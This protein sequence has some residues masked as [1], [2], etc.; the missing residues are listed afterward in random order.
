M[1][2]GGCISLGDGGELPFAPIV[3]ALRGLPAILAENA[4]GTLGRI[5]E[6][7]SPAT[8]ELGRL[9]PELGSS[10][11]AEQG[12][13]DRPEWVQARIFEGLLSLLRAL[14][15]WAPVLLILEEITCRPPR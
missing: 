13:F 10:Q 2:Q 6:L 8:T 1:L 3:E 9:I 4:S 14:G 7:R 15:E 5:D 11:G 12:T